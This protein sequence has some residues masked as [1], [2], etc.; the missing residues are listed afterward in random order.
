[1]PQSFSAV[2]AACCVTRR[3]VWDELGGFD[4]ED[5][6][7]CYN[8]VDYC[9]RAREAGYLVVWTPY[10]HLLHETS[11]SQRAN[12]ER[13]AVEER[14]ARFAREKLAMF[15]KWMPVIADDPAYNRNLSSFGTGFAV[16]VEGAPT[17]DPAFRPRERVLVYCADRE[18]C[19]EYR[20]IAP[21]RA[22]FQSGLVHTFETMRLMTP[23]EVARI[24]PDS[25]VFQRQL[26]PGQIEVIEWVKQTSKAFRVFELDDLITNLPP[27]SAHRPHIAADIGERIKQ[28]L[29]LCDRFV[30]STE[31]MARAYGKFCGDTV[32]VANRLEKVSLAPVSTRRA[33]TAKPRARLGGRG[34]P[35]GR[36]GGH[37][38]GRRGR[39]RRMS[40]GYFSG[41][42]PMGSSATSRSPTPG[43]RCTTTPRHSPRSTSISRSRRSNTIRSTRRRAIFACSNMA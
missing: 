30:C 28:A 12:V 18:G 10:A 21:S 36:S 13:K 39:R 17:W 15:R 1:M 37:R 16:E 32:V 33:A 6:V 43:F 42:A 3:A 38:A 8:D 2:T 5:F 26:E 7:V 11:V 27:K 14:N 24:A 19:G 4:E 35:S 22:L 9:L 23:P 29:A 31:P 34:G 25:I 40:T 41:C 20:I